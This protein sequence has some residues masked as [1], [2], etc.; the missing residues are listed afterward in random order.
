MRRRREL[1]GN[2]Y[3]FTVLLV[4]IWYRLLQSKTVRSFFNLAATRR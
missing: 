4:F 3:L 2:V 1:L